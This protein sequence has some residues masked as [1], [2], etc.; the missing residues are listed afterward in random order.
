VL[1]ADPQTDSWRPGMVRSFIKAKG[2]RSTRASTVFGQTER[3]PLV[4]ESVLLDFAE[5]LVTAV[6]CWEQPQ[7]VACWECGRTVTAEEVK[8][9]IWHVW[10]PLEGCAH[11]AASVSEEAYTAWI[12]EIERRILARLGVPA[13]HLDR[14]TTR[15]MQ[16][17][18]DPSGYCLYPDV[19]PAL[20]W[21]RQNG[22]RTA[23]V[24]NFAWCLPEL[25]DALGLGSLVD[26]VVTSARA[27]YRKP[28]PEIFHLAL[29]GLGA[30]AERAIF[31][32]DDPLCDIG[33]AQGAGMAAI[34]LARR[35]RG[36]PGR[37]ASLRA[38]PRLICR[39]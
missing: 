5:T 12:G 38:L 27:G 2:S 7:I 18:A 21:L 29:A 28:R 23:I 25:T 6:P 35:R 13:D 33:G 37:I 16:L 24:S 36:G 34:L 22:I 10:E 11:P 15:V 30:S 8:E 17:Q 1:L 39:G 14:A 9:A 26:A 4:V 20:T 31:I 19:L 3:G 32:G